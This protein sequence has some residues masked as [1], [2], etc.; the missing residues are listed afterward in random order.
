MSEQN[1]RNMFRGNSQV[2]RI[3]SMPVFW[4]LGRVHNWH[5]MKTVLY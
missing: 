2:L 4:Q 3:L 5:T 1:Y